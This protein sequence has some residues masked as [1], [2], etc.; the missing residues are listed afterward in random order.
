MEIFISVYGAGN[1]NH[2]P[3]RLYYSFFNIS[4]VNSLN[5]NTL[6]QQVFVLFN[7]ISK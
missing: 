7:F 3:I 6:L 2:N 1:K 5:L 4:Y